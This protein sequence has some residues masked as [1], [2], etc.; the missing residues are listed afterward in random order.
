MSSKQLEVW[1][2]ITEWGNV[3]ETVRSM[4]SDY[5]AAYVGGEKIKTDGLKGHTSSDDITHYWHTLICQRLKWNTCSSC[6][7]INNSLIIG[8]GVNCEDKCQGDRTKI[9]WIIQKKCLYLF[10]KKVF[11]IL[12]GAK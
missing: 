4:G 12:L 3:I 8:N 7:E 2:L 11:H 10:H 6:K 9:L 5:W 1:V